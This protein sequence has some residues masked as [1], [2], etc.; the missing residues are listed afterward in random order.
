MGLTVDDARM[1]L[2]RFVVAP[3]E[4]ASER[5]PLPSGIAHQVRSVLRLR[6]GDRIVL[7]DGAGTAAT[8]RLEGGACVVEARGP[9]GGEPAHRLTVW[10][11]LLRGDHLEPVIRHGAEVGVASFR[12]F[13]SDRCVARE[14][15]ERRLQRLR[16]VAREAT[17]QS[18][19]GIVPDVAAPVPFGEAL[20]RASV[21]L[22][23][24]NAGERLSAL[25]PPED[26][27]IGP[28]G[29]FTPD[30]VAAAE[31]AGLVLAGLGPRILRAESVGVAAAAVILSRTGDFA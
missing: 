27:V 22:Y 12:L 14:I 10:Q 7:L 6:D 25:D 31:S 18:E 1:T 21:L 9:A 20:A 26:I 17:E 2:H 29:G 5:F 24:R 30:E 15:S 8:T 11:A 28:E 16:A 3:A 4:M 23:E 13:V 19:R